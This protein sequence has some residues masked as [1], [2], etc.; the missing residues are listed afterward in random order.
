M[1]SAFGF[2]EGAYIWSWRLVT[3]HF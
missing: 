3:F 2:C 1:V